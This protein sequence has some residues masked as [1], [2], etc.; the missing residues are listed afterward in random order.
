MRKARSDG[1]TI[2]DRN[3][4][5]KLLQA[6]PFLHVPDLERA[7]DLFTRVLRFDVKY[8]LSEYAYVAREGAAIRIIEEPGRNLHLEEKVRMIVYIDVVDV[9]ALY[10]ELLTELTT[11]PAGDV[12]PPTDQPWG[13]R[14]LLVRLP[15][16]QWLAFGQP[17]A[18]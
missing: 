3:G 7:L 18:R 12:E 14:E 1:K 11:L 17:I 9:D 13:Q 10:S 6:T 8:R 2:G 4:M 16:R 15:D 5:P